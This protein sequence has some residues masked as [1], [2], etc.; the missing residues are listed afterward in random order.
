[1]KTLPKGTK[2]AICNS[3]HADVQAGTIGEVD[4]KVAIGYGVKVT[5]NFTVPGGSKK[6]TRVIYCDAKDIKKL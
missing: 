5:A 4:C 2:V 1:M 3:P 6:E